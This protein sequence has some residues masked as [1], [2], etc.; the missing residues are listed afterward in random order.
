MLNKICSKNLFSTF[1]HPPFH[2]LTIQQFDILARRSHILSKA[3]DAR[4]RSHAFSIQRQICAHLLAK[5]FLLVTNIFFAITEN[6]VLIKDFFDGVLFYL[7]MTTKSQHSPLRCD[8]HTF[9]PTMRR[10]PTLGDARRSSTNIPRPVMLLRC[11]KM[12]KRLPVSQSCARARVWATMEQ[13][14]VQFVPSRV[15]GHN[16]AI[17]QGCR[18]QRSRKSSLQWRC[19]TKGCKGC[20]MIAENGVVLQEPSPHNCD[21]STIQPFRPAPHNLFSSVQP[22]CCEMK[23]APEHKSLLVSSTRP[24]HQY[25]P[26]TLN[27]RVAAP[28]ALPTCHAFNFGECECVDEPCFCHP[29]TAMCAGATKSGKTEWA[30]R[31][32][33]N[34]CHL[35]HPPPDEIIWCFS[36][37]QPSYEELRRNPQVRLVEGL[38]NI[39]YL[40]STPYRR[41][42]LV[43]DDLLMEGDGKKSGV[44]QLFTKGAHHWNCS[45]I[46]IV[47]NLFYG[48]I[49]TARINSHY[50]ILM[51]NPSDKLQVCQL[52]RQLFPTKQ[53][54]FLEAYGDATKEPYG[55]LV[56]DLAPNTNEKL[57]L[58]S[59]V[60]P[61]EFQCVYML[62]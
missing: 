46:H 56:V 16:Q 24:M 3:C 4:R 43:M 6:F 39:D 51:R 27:E 25:D 2:I 8:A 32:A 26:K 54:D 55:Y 11:P 52:A 31:F 35:M 13:T 10:S 23:E 58:R 48:N 7:K 34:A 28:G 18:Y 61:S 33:L 47:Q 38:P 41:K 1:W 50:L 9:F 60:F 15:Q 44:T 57:R 21:P 62:D 53:N 42:L 12:Y 59:H 5:F 19:A 17:Y 36:E 20:M 14:R 37:Y 30:K 40:K 49:R 29:F 22:T 45:C